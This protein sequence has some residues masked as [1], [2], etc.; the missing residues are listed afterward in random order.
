MN[1]MKTLAILLAGLAALHSPTFAATAQTQHA[2]HAHKADSAKRA[3]HAQGV[4]APQ[5]T[6]TGTSTQSATAATST[7]QDGA[8]P[9]RARA[10][11]VLDEI[12]AVV[13]KDV[14]TENELEDRVHSVALNLRRQN[15]QLPPMEQLRKQVLERLILERIILQRAQ[16]TGLRVDDQM[17]NASIEQIAQQNNMTVEALRQRLLADGVAFSAFRQQIRDEIITQRL[18]EREVDQKIDI[19]ETEVNTYLADQAQQAKGLEYHLA[20]IVLPIDRAEN[21]DVIKA[22]AEKVMSQARSGQAFDTLAATYSRSEDA[23]HGGDLGWHPITD[24]PPSL[25]QV[26][27]GTIPADG[28]FL[29]R[30]ND[31]W[32]IFKV[33]EQRQNKSNPL[34]GPVEETHVRHILMFTSEL[35]PE[36]DVLRRL[37]DIRQR[38]IK[39]ETD[40]ATM[41]RLNSVDASSTRGGDL[42]WV[43]P[44]DTVPAF[45]QVMNRLALN[46]I[47]LPVKT[48]FGYHLIQVLERKKQEQGNP[49]RQRLL[50]RQAIREKK[51]AEATYNWQRQLRDEAYVEIRDNRP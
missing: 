5:G 37:N 15:I 43:L 17:V 29:V 12:V 30:V 42:G 25:R 33:L 3:T 9:T 11:G 23:L 45:E 2:A 19:S 18:R 1:D 20:R 44:G 10:N 21:D 49:E 36:S 28:I 13:N 48:Q 31:S 7:S 27:S 50:A 34:L 39:G 16:E 8:V 22:L 24:F 46:E 51:L 35:M 26:L 40:F 47:S 32:Q 4:K 38:I 6:Q 14:I 41:A